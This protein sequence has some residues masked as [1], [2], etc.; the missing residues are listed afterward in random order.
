MY[1]RIAIWHV[2]NHTARG[3][4]AVFGT[5]I[6]KVL[7]EAINRKIN[8]GPGSFLGILLT[9]SKKM[10]LSGGHQRRKNLE[11]CVHL[12]AKICNM[13]VFIQYSNSNFRKT[14][15]YKTHHKGDRYK[16]QTRTS[17]TTQTYRQC[18]HQYISSCVACVEVMLVSDTDTC[19][20]FMTSLY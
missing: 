13:L 18:K 19:W 16:T 4:S 3:P 7:L 20:M 1:P 17:D 15:R 8:N 2:L 5:R 12:F 14:K 10:S 6:V 11:F 9:I